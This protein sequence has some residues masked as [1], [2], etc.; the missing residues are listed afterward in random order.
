MSRDA[1]VRSWSR[2][3][4]LRSTESPGFATSLAGAIE[5]VGGV[6][7]REPVAARRVDNVPRILSKDPPR[8]EER[9]LPRQPWQTQGEGGLAHLPR[10]LR[11][12]EE[13]GRAES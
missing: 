6:E 2:I 8:V 5:L 10:R 9:E 3:A 1:V 13:T 4:V 11:V 7:W 12:R